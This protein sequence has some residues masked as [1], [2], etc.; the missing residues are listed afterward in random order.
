MYDYYLRSEK[1]DVMTLYEYVSLV[2]GAKKKRSKM[3]PYIS[4]NRDGVMEGDGPSTLQPPFA[5]DM[6]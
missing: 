3:A 5:N 6:R 1:Y 4:P 2:C